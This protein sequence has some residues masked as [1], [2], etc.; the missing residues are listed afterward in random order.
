MS[1]LKALATNVPLETRNF[2][3]FHS[4]L[5]SKITTLFFDFPTQ[6]DFWCFNVTFNNISAIS[7]R[8]DLV[9]EEAGV[10]GENHRPWASK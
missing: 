10:P 1:C 7:L 2:V 8:P 5:K 9:V 4:Y 3:T 6:F